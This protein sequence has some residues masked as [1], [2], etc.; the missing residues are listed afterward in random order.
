MTDDQ[1]EQE[2]RSQRN[3]GLGLGLLVAIPLVLWLT[4]IIKLYDSADYLVGLSET[5]NRYEELV[6]SLRQVGVKKIE[7]SG[8]LGG[9]YEVFGLGYPLIVRVRD[10]GMADH[11][12]Q[13][14]LFKI[15]L[16]DAQPRV[17]LHDPQGT[18]TKELSRLLTDILKRVG[19]DLDDE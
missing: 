10:S 7:P 11:M 3:W 17:R 15:D 8:D 13:S 19:R 16:S 12:V 6:S 14:P 18:P 5:G 2:H 4:G 1:I 9:N